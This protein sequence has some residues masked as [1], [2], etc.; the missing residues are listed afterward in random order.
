MG[1]FVKQHKQYV[2]GYEFG[3]LLNVFRRKIL[4]L[5]IAVAERE[6]SRFEQKHGVKLTF[7]PFIAVAAIEAL[8]HA[9][10]SCPKSFIEYGG[11]VAELKRL[12][13]IGQ[14]K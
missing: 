1:H 12:G 3:D 5:R 9:V 11:A 7:M 14:A 4:E 6:R 8:R 10:E 2:A 13:Q